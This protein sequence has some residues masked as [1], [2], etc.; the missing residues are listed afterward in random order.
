MRENNADLTKEMINLLKQQRE[1]ANLTQEEI[2]KRLGFSPKSGKMYISAFERGKK[3]NPSI[4]TILKYLR[5]CGASWPEFFKEL[6]RIDF[7][8]RHEKMIGQLPRPP[9]KRKIERDAMRYEI[10]IEFPSKE[11]EEIDFGRLKKQIRDKVE[12]LLNKEGVNAETFA[13]Q[14]FA[15]EFFDFMATLNKAGMRMVSD[16]YL[17]VGLQFNL[18]S[19]IKK[20]INS[21]IYGEM[22]RIEAKKPLPTEKQEKMA[23]GF[24]QYRII[25]ER[26]EGEVHNLLCE[27]GM[28]T[29]WFSL[30]Q[31]FA[32]QCYVAL[33]KYFGKDQERLTRHL[34]ELIERW[35]K[36]GLEETVLVKVKDKIIAVF[37]DMRRKGRV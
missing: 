27:L 6:D 26:I 36:E 29:A 37:G 33:R 28:K 5:A 34:T 23:I 16:K 8:L 20:I 14:K 35:K 22:K 32:R 11:K 10:N 19:K 15:L 9:E 4:D 21:V 24:T 1:K 7:R 17:R 2:A 3:R 30:Y 31:D 18:I 12:A 13:Y 25:I